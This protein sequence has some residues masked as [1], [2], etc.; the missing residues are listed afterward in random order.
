ML[1]ASLAEAMI[2]GAAAVTAFMLASNSRWQRARALW[3][4]KLSRF[5]TL[6]P[7]SWRAL[8]GLECGGGARRSAENGSGRPRAAR[9]PDHTIRPQPTRRAAS[10]VPPDMGLAAARLALA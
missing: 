8:R 1:L 6:K 3:F 4:R 7:S 5:L 10:W 2:G 9:M